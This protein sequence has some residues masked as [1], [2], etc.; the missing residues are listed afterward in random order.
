[1]GSRRLR[2][3]ELARRRPP[4]PAVSGS[5]AVFRKSIKRFFDTQLHAFQARYLAGIGKH[6]AQFHAQPFVD[7][8]VDLRQSEG[9]GR[10]FRSP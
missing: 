2:Y 3:G 10:H 9:S 5:F 6:L 8:L 1:M 7:P 4:W